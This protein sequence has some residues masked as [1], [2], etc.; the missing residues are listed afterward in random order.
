MHRISVEPHPRVRALDPAIP[1][2]FE[3]IV[4]RALA[5]KP[6]DRYARAAEMA[7]EL[8]RAAR[9]ATAVGTAYE[10]TT[11]VEAVRDQLLDDPDAFSRP[12]DEQ[13]QALLPPPHAHPQ[14]H[15]HD[16]PPPPPA[17]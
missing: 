6:Q 17:P 15:A 5:K 4:D 3:R 9:E 8:R 11:K 10:K 16:P 13:P 12:V 1:A 2:A 14:P 7:E